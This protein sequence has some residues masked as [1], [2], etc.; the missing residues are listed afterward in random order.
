MG[1]YG[2]DNRLSIRFFL[3][4]P[5]VER[6][7]LRNGPLE[8]EKQSGLGANIYETVLWLMSVKFALEQVPPRLNQ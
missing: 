5:S 2:V 7:V 1:E 3:C 8:V 6:D 4:L